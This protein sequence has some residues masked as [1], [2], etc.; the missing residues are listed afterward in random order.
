MS[1]QFPLAKVS[2]KVEITRRN[3]IIAKGVVTA[4]NDTEKGLWVTVDVGDKKN[5]DPVKVRASQLRKPS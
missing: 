1:E 3:G 4:T 5:P 2:K